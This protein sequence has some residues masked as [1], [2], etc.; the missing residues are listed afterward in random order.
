MIGGQV[1]NAFTLFRDDPPNLDAVQTELEAGRSVTFQ[2]AEED[3][4]LSGLTLLKQVL[5]K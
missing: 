5:E 1:T 4:P 2:I 3:V